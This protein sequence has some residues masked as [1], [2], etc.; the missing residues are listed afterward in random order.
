V[1][2]HPGTPRLLA[3][4]LAVR[5]RCSE[6][7][8]VRLVVRRRGRALTVPVRVTLASR[9]VSRRVVLRLNHAGRVR[10]HRHRAMP[11]TLIAR[12]ADT[13]RNTRTLSVALRATR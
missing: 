2:R 1:R 7:C 4:G 11:L 12:A 10:L 8:T 13:A 5:L 3:R 6:R 9:S